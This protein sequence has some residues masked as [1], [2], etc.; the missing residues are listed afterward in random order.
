[1]S[2]TPPGS[3]TSWYNAYI[4]FTHI[5]SMLYDLYNVLCTLEHLVLPHHALI[6]ASP[7]APKHTGS[8]LSTNSCHTQRHATNASSEGIDI[9]LPVTFYFKPST[10]LDNVKNLWQFVISQ[11]R[12]THPS[13][14]H[15]LCPLQP[16]CIFHFHLTSLT[17][18]GAYTKVYQLESYATES[19]HKLHFRHKAYSLDFKFRRRYVGLVL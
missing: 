9:F 17:T 4:L 5:I 3:S 7:S 13:F 19:T 10:R 12:T 1:M 15:P 11:R 18:I 2:F 8:V 14:H 16:L 6:V